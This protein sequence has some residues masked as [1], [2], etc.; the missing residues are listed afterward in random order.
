MQSG[1]YSVLLSEFTMGFNN[2]S[3]F[4]H[5]VDGGGG[6]GLGGGVPRAYCSIT[7]FLGLGREGDDVWVCVQCVIY[8]SDCTV[9]Y[10]CVGEVLCMHIFNK[11]F[12]VLKK[13]VA[14]G[15]FM[16]QDCKCP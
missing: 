13:K 4:S 12:R 8:K 5:R 11:E 9:L 15:S 2:M 1:V 3:Y 16:E 10:R 14:H 7:K 6:D